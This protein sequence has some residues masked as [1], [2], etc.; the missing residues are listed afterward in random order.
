MSTE[1]QWQK[2][3][4]S[5]AGGEDCVEIAA[6]DGRILMRESDNPDTV[7]TPS[8]VNLATLLFQVKSGALD[9][10]AE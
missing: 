6:W 3:S 5:G 2:S 8:L 1:I 7:A 9:R 10:F 4:F